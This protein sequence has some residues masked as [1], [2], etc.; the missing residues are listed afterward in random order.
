[1]ENL[2][3]KENKLVIT[4]KKPFDIVAKREK[5]QTSGDGGI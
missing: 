5:V 4:W 3:L 1:M 2:E